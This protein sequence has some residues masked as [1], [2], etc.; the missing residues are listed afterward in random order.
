MGGILLA[1]AG[2]GYFL[3]HASPE[4]LA[5]TS[6]AL[7]TTGLVGL[8]VG[9]YVIAVRQSL[10]G[11]VHRRGHGRKDGPPPE[12]GHPSGPPM[13]DLDAELF[14]ILDDARLGDISVTRRAHGRDRRAGAT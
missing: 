5:A 12:P 2:A 6:W 3:T 4:A 7:I 11:D 1:G 13:A 10:T 8:V 14:R 9:T